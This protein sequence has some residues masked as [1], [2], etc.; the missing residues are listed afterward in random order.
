MSEPQ[1]ATRLSRRLGTGDAVA[2]GLGA[3]LGAGA[4]AAPAP[5]AALAGSGILLSLVVA[6]L[7]AY[8]NATSTA[9]LAAVQPE[10][11]GV[12][13]YGRAR[14]G[15]T[16]GFTAGWAFAA[17]N[18]SSLVAMALTF[19][20]YAV[21]GQP[22]LGALAAVAVLTVI[23]LAGVTRTATAAKAGA[24]AV[25]SVLVAVAL[26]T[27]GSQSADSGN[28]FPVMG[29]SGLSGVLGGAGI[30][31]FAFAGYARI[32]TLGEEVRNPKVTI[33]RA[34]PIA[35]ATAF[36]LYALAIGG[37]LIVLGPDGLASAKA[38]LVDAVEAAG[39][40]SIAPVVRAG[41]AVAALGVLLSLLAGV[42]RTAFAMADDR[43]LPG[44]L[45]AVHGKRLVPHVAQ[46]T[47]GVIVAVLVLIVPTVSAIA[48]SS[49]CILVYYSIAH[50]SALKLD[51]A[52]RRPRVLAPL[53]LIG[54]VALAAS[55]PAGDVIAGLG[56]IVL[57]LL[58]RAVTLAFSRRR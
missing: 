27:F 48:T 24:V 31:F 12:Y 39:A 19:G 23:N 38:P 54:C 56:L 21:P 40:G 1:P 53:G 43:E 3:M 22:K 13:S 2:I 16:A 11:G 14:L 44:A 45:A 42:A 47:V 5:A 28:L 15:P 57:G 4:F 18:I 41:A 50:L 17:G 20:A 10:A 32:A 29:D 8:A 34:V 55:L 36:A 33:P 6:G 30:M 9:R 25:A 51:E 37:A 46:I 7:V 58:G 49:V 26:A 35:L 52:D